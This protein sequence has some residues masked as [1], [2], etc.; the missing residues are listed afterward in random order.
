[1]G[2]ATGGG[3]LGGGCSQQVFLLFSTGGKKNYQRGCFPPAC[4]H[5]AGGGVEK[6]I[7]VIFDLGF[8]K[9]CSLVLFTNLNLPPKEPSLCHV[10]AIP[11]PVLI[12]N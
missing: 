3:R 9:S 5:L 7:H 2:R 8:S 6:H 1:M 10:P 4:G 11:L 12:P